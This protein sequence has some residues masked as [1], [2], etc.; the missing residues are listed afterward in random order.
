MG[1]PV[2]KSSLIAFKIV[3]RSAYALIRDVRNA[4][5]KDDAPFAHRLQT[6][7]LLIEDELA[8]VEGE[9]KK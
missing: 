6:I 2:V 9:I 5:Q 4:S 1:M 3:M 8:Y 7:L